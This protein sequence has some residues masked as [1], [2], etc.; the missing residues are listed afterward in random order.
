MAENIVHSSLGADSRNLAVTGE[1]ISFIEDA[2]ILRVNDDSECWDSGGAPVLPGGTAHCTKISNIAYDVS[3]AVQYLRAERGTQSASYPQHTPSAPAL[4]VCRVGGVKNGHQS[5]SFAPVNSYL[6]VYPYGDAARPVYI[7]GDYYQNI[8]IDVGSGEG[9]L[10]SWTEVCLTVGR[11]DYQRVLPVPNSDPVE[12][13]TLNGNHCGGCMALFAHNMLIY[14]PDP[15]SLHIARHGYY[16]DAMSSLADDGRGT[17]G[18]RSWHSVHGALGSDSF[19]PLIPDWIPVEEQLLFIQRNCLCSGL[20]I[21]VSTLSGTS[22]N[23]KLYRLTAQYNHNGGVPALIHDVTYTLPYE[24]AKITNISMGSE[25]SNAIFIPS[26][27][28]PGVAFYDLYEWMVYNRALTEEEIV[29][30]YYAM[31]ERYGSF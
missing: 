7:R 20:T 10:S 12:Y 13:Y 17:P 1:D 21:C 14:V 23:R 19:E 2:L 31:R 5:F 16:A 26:Y 27:G 22:L 25:I 15:P 8:N 6:D 30:L 29:K 28:A 24:V 4:G 11:L 9:R 18:Y 3:G